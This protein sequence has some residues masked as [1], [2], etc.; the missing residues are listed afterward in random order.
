MTVITRSQVKQQT[1]HKYETRTQHA[2]E[3]MRQTYLEMMSSNDKQI[4]N[5]V[6]TVKDDPVSKIV[7]RSQRIKILM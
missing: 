7:R 5:K 3:N 6:S 2:K 1:Q 4:K